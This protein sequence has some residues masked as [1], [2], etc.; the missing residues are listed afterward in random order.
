MRPA[1]V[2]TKRYWGLQDERGWEHP[3]CPGLAAVH[4]TPRP[5]HTFTDD[6]GWAIYHVRSGLSLF[7]VADPE[8]AALALVELGGLD[9][10]WT[11]SGRCLDT[12]DVRDGVVALRSRLSGWHPARVAGD[13]SDIEDGAR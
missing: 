8:T 4:V 5:G 6:P 7:S 9:V 10:D 11:R 1:I 12:A 2:T 3:A 13:P